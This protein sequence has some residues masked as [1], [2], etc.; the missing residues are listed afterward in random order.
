MSKRSSRISEKARKSSLTTPP[1]A[2]QRK[3]V[4]STDPLERKL[5]GEHLQPAVPAVV[6]QVLGSPG[7]PLTD[8]TQA[9]MEQRFDRDFSHVRV[10]T[11]A[12]A[13]DSA[14]LVNAKAYTVGND[15]VFGAGR[16]SEQTAEGQ[17]LLAHEL[18]HVA[19]PGGA[20]SHG[21]SQP[22]DASEREADRAADGFARGEVVNVGQAR[23]AV[24]QRDPLPGINQAAAGDKILEEAS[25]F[26]AAALG[27]ETLD[28]YA[29]GKSEL[30][31]AHAAKLATVAHRIQVLL[32][33]Y[34]LSTITVIGHADT[35][36]TESSNLELGQ[37]RAEVVKQALADLGIAGSIIS[38]ESK[39]E[40][41]PAVKTKD[42]TSSAPNR[43]VE[44][45]FHPKSFHVNVMTEKLK[46]PT[47]GKEA[48]ETSVPPTKPPIDFN[49][50][51]KFEL[52]DPTQVNPNVWKPIPPAPKGSGPKSALE[53]IG[54]KVLD[55]AIDAV[56]G[57][58]PKSA[59]DKLKEGARSAVKAGSA[60]AA[61]AAAEAAG[62]TDPAALDA[63][64]KAAEAA[65]QE[66]GQPRK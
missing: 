47:L 55:P 62:V 33:K 49:Y 5:D 13:A 39:G 4:S 21:V 65:I 17:K 14:R 56:A 37:E 66:K 43:R 20:G 53:V 7:Q 16:F 44:I 50:H 36:G 34:N 9:R 59:R 52:P 22:G 63:I 6:D 38:T 45:R 28:D 11:D 29:T 41:S 23:S 24:V 3:A 35:V 54:E 10:H 12:Q 8:E 32:R 25:P 2:L 58:L 51:P 26:L 57:W 1:I 27:S 60:K 46:P 15:V 30:K 42:E 61:R 64:E 31:P 18:A 19:Q 40:G 48:P